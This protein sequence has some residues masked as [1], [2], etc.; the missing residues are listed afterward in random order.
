[1]QSMRDRWSPSASALVAGVLVCLLAGA[2]PRAQAPPAL[3]LD[4]AFARA[5]EANPTI[6]AARLRRPIDL[7]AIDV[8]RERPNPEAHVEFERETPKESYGMGIPIELGGK[9]SKRIAVGEATLRTGEAELAQ[10]TIEVRNAVRRAYFTRAIAEARLTLL[11]ELRDIATRA[12]DA[13]QARFTAGSAP[14]LEVL[15]AELAL[16]QVDNDAVSATASAEGARVQLNALLA[17]PLDSA[18]ALATPAEAGAVVSP[19]DAATRAQ[20]SSSEI[21]VLNRRI[22]EQRA[23]LALAQANRVPDITPDG[24]ITRNAEPEFNVG[25][26]ALVAM[27]V[28]IVTQHRAGI[29]VEEATLAQLAGERAAAL[30]RITGDAVSA[31]TVAD[32]QRQQYLRY[33][34][35]ILPQATEVERMA[36]DSYRLGQTGIS[37]FLQALQATRDARLRALQA[38]LDFQN[39]LA[40]LERAMGTPLP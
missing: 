33:R 3:T 28:P 7:A 36:E 35:Q 21:A 27:T 10:A 30:A 34:D 17:L 14:R 31:A 2:V 12:R 24:T 26:R 1:M 20:A 29:R 22:E 15:Q 16:A 23:K 11:T 38:A 39:A 9:R 4:A 5:L 18:P 40:D 13:A 8:A 32:A 6:A 37:A 19:A 25:W